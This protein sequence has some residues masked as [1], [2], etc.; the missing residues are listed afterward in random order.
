V[1]GGIRTFVALSLPDAH[2]EALTAHLSECAG[3]A[4]QYRW[5]EPDALHLTLRFIGHL[6]L[7][8]LDDVR[9]GL[10]AIRAAPFRLALNGRG[11]FGS[12]SAPRVVWLGVGEGLDACAALAAAADG[13]CRSA[14]LE[15]DARGFRAHVTLA[16]QRREGE[17]L[18]ALPDPPPL[19]PWTVEDFVL[20]ESRLQKQPRYVPIDRYRLAV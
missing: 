20:Y 18:A 15:A 13:A 12:R 8:A 11:V 7:E 3:L 5:V 4:P 16:R 14:G 9:R 6:Q 19:P 2:R 17:R 10:A 1:A